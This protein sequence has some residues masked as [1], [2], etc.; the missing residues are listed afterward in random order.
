MGH[1][2]LRKKRAIRGSA[3][4]LHSSASAPERLR[5]RYYRLS[6]LNLIASIKFFLDYLTASKCF[7]HSTESFVNS[8]IRLFKRTL[9][10]VIILRQS[11][12]EHNSY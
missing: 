4:R 1:F 9:S 11:K 2:C 12:K 6:V 7:M 8:L 3:F 5:R 10:F